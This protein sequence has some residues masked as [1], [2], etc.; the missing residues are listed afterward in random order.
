MDEFGARDAKVY[1][2][3]ATE[4]DI[5][6]YQIFKSWRRFSGLTGLMKDIEERRRSNYAMGVGVV[7]GVSPAT[8]LKYSVGTC[9][10][11]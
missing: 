6:F 2:A 5:S 11:T 3:V 4:D 10:R 9:R 8:R 7:G 1:R